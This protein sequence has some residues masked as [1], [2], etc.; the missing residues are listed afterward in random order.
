MGVCSKESVIAV[1]LSLW[2]VKQTFDNSEPFP[3]ERRPAHG[4]T[5]PTTPVSGG[6]LVAILAVDIRVNPRFLD[7]L[8]LLGGFVRS[9]PISLGIPPQPGEGM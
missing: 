1:A 3:V 8:V 2:S 4:F 5:S 6:A 9:R 7:A